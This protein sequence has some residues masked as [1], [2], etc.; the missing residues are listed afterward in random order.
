MK[1]WL[2]NPSDLFSS[3]EILP[4]SSMNNNEKLNALTRLIILISV[5]F[6][7]MGNNR[8]AICVSLIGI[9]VIILVHNMIL[10]N[11]IEGWTYPRKYTA[12]VYDSVAKPPAVPSGMPSSA[13]VISP[14]LEEWISD[15]NSG[16][17]QTNYPAMLN[18]DNQTYE[19]PI[20]TLVPENNEIFSP[21]SASETKEYKKIGM[22]EFLQSQAQLNT[23][24]M[25][26]QMNHIQR[27]KMFRI[28]R[29]QNRHIENPNGFP[30]FGLNIPGYE[31]QT[32][33]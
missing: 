28:Q 5:I 18:Y 16:R 11:P 7:F 1:F 2:E 25:N 30:E 6:Y 13:Q 26:D 23:S 10:R 32:V 17:P 22:G 21:F 20:T 27:E 4:C 3:L 15:I 14:E 24:R 8:M 12:T 29:T 31:Q 19:T 33:L 9:A